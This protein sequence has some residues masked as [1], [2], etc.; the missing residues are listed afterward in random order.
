MTSNSLRNG[1]I[2]VLVALGLA[3]CGSAKRFDYQ[4]TADEMRPGPGL[5][6]GEDGE[7]VIFGQ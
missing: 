2:V 5:F 7:F 1:L 4:A 3:A 6:S